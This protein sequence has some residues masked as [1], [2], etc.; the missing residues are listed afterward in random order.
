MVAHFADF[1]AF[2]AL[3]EIRL[4]EL[5]RSGQHAQITARDVRSIDP[6]RVL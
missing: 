6:F 4:E 3:L 5:M 2:Q 1:P